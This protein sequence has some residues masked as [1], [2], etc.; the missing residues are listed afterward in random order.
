MRLSRVLFVT[1]FF[2]SSTLSYAQ[3][4]PVMTKIGKISMDEVAMTTFAPDTS[5][6]ALV[7]WENDDIT[8]DFDNNTS[9][10]LMRQYHVLRIKVLKDEGKDYADGYLLTRKSYSEHEAIHKLSVVTYNLENGKIVETRLPKSEII[11]STHDEDRY[12]TAF[13]AQNVKVGSVIEVSYVFETA[14]FSDIPDFYFQ[15]DVPVNLSEYRIAIPEWIVSRNTT[16]GSRPLDMKTSTDFS[17]AVGYDLNIHEYRAVDLPALN[18][19]ENV[20][21]VSQYRLAVAYDIIA[22]NLPGNYKNFSHSWNDIAKAV[23]DSHIAKRIKA[24]CKF[25]DELGPIM[26]KEES[27]KN[28]LADVVQLVRSKVS[29][30]DISDLIPDKAADIL[31]TGSG[32]N[33]DINALFGS[34]CRSAGFKV[35]PVLVRKRSSGNILDFRPYLAAFSTFIINVKC[36]NGEEFF[37][38]AADP[39]GFPNIL[40]DDYLITKGFQVDLD[41]EGSFEWKDL[42]GL[43]RSMTSYNV[44]A[45]ISEDGTLTGDLSSTMMGE[46]SYDFKKSYRKYDK[47]E[48]FIENVES[49]MSAEIDGFNLTDVD[50][51]SQSVKMNLKFEKECEGGSD[52]IMINPF[53]IPFHSEKTFREETRELPVD[54]EYPESIVY[55]F[56]LTVPDGYVVDQIPSPVKYVSDLPSQLFSKTVTDGKTV[57]VMYKFD[58][59]AYIVLPKAYQDLR[60]YWG[61]I[62]SIYKQMIILKKAQ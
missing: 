17:K 44:M 51:Y 24:D 48:D 47:M 6:A 40:N 12:K 29:W 61:D 62:C 20:Y 1:V 45:T 9:G 14:R 31:K 15:K 28:K 50:K 27:N 2:L 32:S 11:S 52:L 56:K 22:M 59:Q 26:A 34:A 46:S 41:T 23:N 38:D 39:S 53:L 4:I 8:I 25:K 18:K 57:S 60:Q 55:S 58:N 3:Q 10:V 21:N 42:T 16:R 19:E 7:L 36:D 54:F 5:A 37:I 49:T 33:A 30:N 13:A 35:S 43:T